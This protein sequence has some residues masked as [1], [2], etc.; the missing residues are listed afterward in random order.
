MLR[1]DGLLFLVLACLS[2]GYVYVCLAVGVCKICIRYFD[3]FG[4]V[5][6][7]AMFDY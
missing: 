5:N 2:D 1:L 3:V 7:I 4:L 6:L